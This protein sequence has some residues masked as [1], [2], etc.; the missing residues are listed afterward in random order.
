MKMD[1]VNMKGA[2]LAKDYSVENNVP[3]LYTCQPLMHYH[4]VCREGYRCLQDLPTPIVMVS[5]ASQCVFSFLVPDLLHHCSQPILGGF[6]CPPP[7]GLVYT[8]Q[9]SF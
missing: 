8:L 9:A 7:V 5:N 1:Q 4:A 3:T 2:N 6:P